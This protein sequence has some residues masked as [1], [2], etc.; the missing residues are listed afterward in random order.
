VLVADAAMAVAAA[1]FYSLP[2]AV[3]LGLTVGLCQ[4]LGK[5]SLDALIQDDVPEN[6]RTS[7]FA[8][9]ETLLQ[10]SW[11][12]GGALGIVMPLQPRLGLGIVA[13]LLLVWLVAVLR[14]RTTIKRR[15]A[16]LAS[17]AEAAPAGR[18]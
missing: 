10:L 4:Q 11:V 13:A 8:R 1:L 14:G 15:Q 18:D 7:V 5:L 3:A 6:V 17:S 9:S 16:R 12:L 2:F